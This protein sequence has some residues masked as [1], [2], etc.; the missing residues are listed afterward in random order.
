[1]ARVYTIGT[2]IENRPILALKLSLTPGSDDPGRPEVVYVGCHHAREWISVEVPLRLAEYV[3]CAAATAVP[4]VVALLQVVELWFIPVLNPDG[5]AF[6][7]TSPGGRYW[8]KNRRVNWDRS[9]GVDIN[10]NYGYLWGGAGASDSPSSELYRGAAPYSEPEVQALRDFLGYRDPDQFLTLGITPGAL[11]CDTGPQDPTASFPL[12]YG[13]H[14]G[15]S[16]RNRS[17]YLKW[18]ATVTFACNYTVEVLQSCPLGSGGATYEVVIVS[19]GTT[20]ASLVGAVSPTYDA[21]MQYVPLG[22]AALSNGPVTIILRLLTLSPAGVLG[23]LYGC[24]LSCRSAPLVPSAL[25]LVSQPVGLLSY[26]SF[27][28]QF[29]WPIGAEYQAPGNAPLLQGLSTRMAE[30]ARGVAR[31]LYFPMIAAS[32]YLASGDAVDWF[33][34]SHDGAPA[35][36]VE[37]A[38]DDSALD[39]FNL[40]PSDIIPVT[41]DNIPPALYFAEYVGRHS[42]ATWLRHQFED[43]IG[44]APGQSG[45]SG[46]FPACPATGQPVCLRPTCPIVAASGSPPARGSITFALFPLVLVASFFVFM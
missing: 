25:G 6:S 45:L 35:F 18:T 15:V 9:V 37:L 20:V 41:L 30:L 10:R 13:Y 39:G 16:W 23:T 28:Q 36:T 26:H 24:Q 11:C 43:D 32:T 29:Q 38:P 46:W 14:S 27:G 12:I 5:Y 42:N 33:W 7:Y 3:V 2:S 44:T 34:H 40:P 22:T 21:Y 31:Q 8:R 19:M 1:M 17:T 4:R